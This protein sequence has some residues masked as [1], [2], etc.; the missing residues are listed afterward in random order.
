VD[1]LPHGVA[2]DITNLDNFESITQGRTLRHFGIDSART[3]LKLVSA[4]AKV[5]VEA[6]GCR[7]LIIDIRRPTMMYETGS[8][9]A[10]VHL[11]PEPLYGII[12]GHWSPWRHTARA[13]PL[14]RAHRFIFGWTQGHRHNRIA[15]QTRLDE[16][17]TTRIK[18]GRC[19]NLAVAV[20]EADIRGLQSALP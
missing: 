3:R 14:D 13:H 2:G 19:A 20:D 5:A 17:V 15:G 18:R 6:Y 4:S 11:P 9:L 12:L 1:P 16:L 8:V 10:N 7:S